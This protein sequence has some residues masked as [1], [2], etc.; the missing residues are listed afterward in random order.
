MRPAT[1]GSL[2]VLLLAGNTIRADEDCFPCEE[3]C[4]PR[5]WASADYLLWWF[6][7][8]PEPVP[9]VTSASFNDA[10]PGAL[11]QANTRVILGGRSLDGDPHSG[12]RFSAGWWLDAD[13]GIG[14]DGNYL[15]LATRTARASVA[16]SGLPGGPDVAVPIFDVSGIAGLSGV[17]G[18]TIFILPGP[19]PGYIVGSS[20]AQVAAF[21]GAFQIASSSRLQ[22]AEINGTALLDRRGG[23]RFDGLAGFRWLQLVEDFSFA[24]QSSGVTGSLASGQFYNIRDQFGTRN[25]FYGG[26]L[27]FRARY[28]MD[29]FSVQAAARIALG[30]TQQVAQVSGGGQTTGGNLF[31]STSGTAN[32]VLPGGIFTQ[33]T[34]IGHFERDVFAVAPEVMLDLGYQITSA[35]RV[36]VGYTF[37]YLSDVARPGDQIDRAVN[38]TRTA[39]ADASRATLGTGTGPIAFGHSGSGLSPR[40][41]G[42]VT[43]A[44]RFHDDSFWA[45]GIHFDLAFEY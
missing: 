36:S 20:A 3:V 28:E 25:N 39:L 15:F 33:P 14:I 22:G 40:P 7:R 45:Q 38:I 2:F 44:F 37:L 35:I 43:P 34:N 16:T 26:Q 31:I 6:K 23:L 29:R 13:S 1:L 10:L 30:A 4:G 18:E 5:F 9:L 8:S 19:F 41:F 32:R 11:G 12:G 21:Q 42:P 24:G 17:P 27:G